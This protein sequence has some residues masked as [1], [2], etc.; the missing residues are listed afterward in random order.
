MSLFMYEKLK[1]YKEVVS[2]K[3]KSHL[4]GWPSKSILSN[5]AWIPVM[6]D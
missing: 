6:M 1:K 3:E 2:R 5:L 4:E